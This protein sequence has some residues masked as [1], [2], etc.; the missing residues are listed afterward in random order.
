MILNAT[1]ARGWNS[2]RKTKN[3]C[4]KFLTSINVSY[5]VADF[6]DERNFDTLDI[7][8]FPEISVEIQDYN[9]NYDF[10]RE[11]ATR[12]IKSLYRVN[13]PPFRI[14]IDGLY[15]I[16]HK[17]NIIYVAAGA[18]AGVVIAVILGPDLLNIL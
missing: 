13:A 12:P 15:W 1:L 3:F 17:N 2:G 8:L 9:F 5:D 7:Q 14:Q 16:L 11:N 18:A 6:T 10:E 4:K